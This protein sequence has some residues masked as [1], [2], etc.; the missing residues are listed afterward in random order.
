MIVLVNYADEAMTRS[1]NLC[2]LSAMKQGVDVCWPQNPNT[3]SSEFKE[4]NRDIWEQGNRGADCYWLFKPYVIYNAMLK[5]REGDMLIYAD[6]GVEF[7]N[8]VS[9]II[10]RM[11]EDIFF[12]TNTHPNHHWTK[13]YTLDKMYP[14]WFN[15]YGIDTKWPQV[16]AS[17]I[18]FRVND[19]TK[20]IVKEWLMWAQMPGI[21][22]DDD[23]GCVPQQG[24]QD[25]RHDQSIITI[26][27]T[28]KGYKLHWW[29]T[30]YA[31]HI[32]VP[33]DNYPV[34]F[35]HHRNRDPGFGNGD[36]EWK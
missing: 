9:Y 14:G 27:A 10:D 3:V 29:P 23:M 13:R 2:C 17:V 8:P 11:D 15:V 30:A 12:F 24:F 6:A 34:I 20:S 21:I 5:L 18:F 19:N 33:G 26:L 7:V 31:E 16:Q 4:I 28:L 35:N 1:Q 32:R 22:N 25:H 36:A